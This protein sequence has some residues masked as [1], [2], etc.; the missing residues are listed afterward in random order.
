MKVVSCV[1]AC[2]LRWSIKIQ[3]QLH[4]S[5]AVIALQREATSLTSQSNTIT[6]LLMEKRSLLLLRAIAR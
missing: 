5:V 2:T 6:S 3:H 1:T 4:W